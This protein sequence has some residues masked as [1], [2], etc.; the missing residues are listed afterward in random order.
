MHLI[1]ITNDILITRKFDRVG[2]YK[3]VKICIFFLIKLR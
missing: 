1:V 3:K 2:M